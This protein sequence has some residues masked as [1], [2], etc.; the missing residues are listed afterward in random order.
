MMK[1]NFVGMQDGKDSKPRSAD[2]VLHALVSGAMLLEPG[3][4]IDLDAKRERNGGR[5]ARYTSIRR[6]KRGWH[7]TVK[8]SADERATATDYADPFSAVLAAIESR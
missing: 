3:E 4:S 8:R 1:I 7:V 2:L 6:T 5:W